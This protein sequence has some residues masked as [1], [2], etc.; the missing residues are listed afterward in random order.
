[1]IGQPQGNTQFAYNDN[2]PNMI[3]AHI[4]YQPTQSVNPNNM[5]QVM[6]NVADYMT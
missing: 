2:L 6:F 3:L 1:M 5:L 4:S